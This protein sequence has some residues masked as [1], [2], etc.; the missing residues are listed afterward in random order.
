MQALHERTDLP[1]RPRLCPRRVK[2]IL[3]AE[4]D[5]DTAA[6]IKAMLE[7]HLSLD[8]TTINNGALVL[9]QIAARRPDLLILDVSLPGLNGVD[10]FDLVQANP[11]FAEVPVLFLTATPDRARRAVG[12]KGIR[13]VM[14]KPFE[15]RALAEKVADLLGRAETV[16]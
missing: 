5:P 3:I 12:R 8:T 16:A 14:R 15:G 2:S 11:S 13:D 4:D 9:D 1:P 10:V 7:E 6:L